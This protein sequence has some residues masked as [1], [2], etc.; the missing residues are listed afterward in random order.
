MTERQ[1]L[2]IGF[3]MREPTIPKYR[4]TQDGDPAKQVAWLQSIFQRHLAHR[5]LELFG[6]VPQI[7]IGQRESPLD[8]ARRLWQARGKHVDDRRLA[9][10]P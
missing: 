6:E 5:R 2:L 4:V 7:Y 3:L 8:K 1:L 9:R 10:K